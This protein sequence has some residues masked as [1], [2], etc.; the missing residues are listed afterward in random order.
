MTHKEETIMAQK[1]ILQPDEVWDYF[2]EHEE[3]CDECMFEIASCS[4][5]G[6]AVYLSRSSKGVGCITVEADDQEVYNEEII[7]AEDTK[8]TVQK[9]YDDYLTDK[10]I[11]ILSDFEPQEDDTLQSQE[12]EIDMREEELDNLIWDFVMGVFGGDT[13]TDFDCT[14][15][16]LDDLKDHFLEY[17]Y[18]KHEFDIYRPMVL[19]DEDGTEFFEE[20]PYEHMVF[21]DEDNPM[22]KD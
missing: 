1:I 11:E 17:M 14:G 13:Y 10:V 2:V 18:R 16:V 3:E 12:D 8:K 19:E 5:Y 6:T 21:D 9:V 20:Y 7:D 15:E 22:Y 4:E